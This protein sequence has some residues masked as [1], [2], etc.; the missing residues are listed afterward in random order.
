MLI[1]EVVP[2]QLYGKAWLGSI[3]FLLEFTFYKKRFCRYALKK[4]IIVTFVVSFLFACSRM[5]LSLVHSWGGTKSLLYFSE[6]V[7]LL[8]LVS[9]LALLL[10]KHKKRDRPHKKGDRPEY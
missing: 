9:F 8:E 1:T 2:F 6:W 7:V 5:N 4:Y 10:S 3:G